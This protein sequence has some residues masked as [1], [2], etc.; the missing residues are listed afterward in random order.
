MKDEGDEPMSGKR[1]LT[2]E[3]HLRQIEAYTAV[4][5]NYRTYAAAI[6]RVLE[7]ACRTSFP[8]AF[9]QSRPKSRS[10]FA[11]K[12]ARKFDK[13]PD[14]VNQMTDLCGGRV[15]VQTIEQVKAVRQFIE[16]NFEILEKED[17]GLLL[18]EDT[19]GYRDMHYIVRL[20]PERD[21]ALGI[22]SGERAAIG[23]RTAEIQVRTW[24]QHAWADTLHDRMYKNDLKLSSEVVR[25][26]ALL[27]AFLEEADRTFH[28]LADELDGLIANYTAFARKDDVRQE[29]AVQR[30]IL[31]HEPDKDKRPALAMKLA[32]LAVASGDSR[33][34]V[35]LLDGHRDLP[36][37]NR[38]ELLLELGYSLCRL[39]RDQPASAEYVRG[40]RLLE[41]AVATCDCQD[42][43][44]APNLRKRD[45]LHARA[46]A[47]LGW[48]LE[49]DGSEAHQ[50]RECYHQAHEHEPANPYYL[51]Q[52]LGFE[53]YCTRG[54]DLPDSMRTTIRRAIRTCLEHAVAGIELPYAHFTA[55]RLSLLLGD[56]YEALGL[57]SRGLRHFLA[58]T[59]CVSG[60]ALAS[61]I[62]WLTRIHF[63]R[64]I[65]PPAQRAIDLLR[66]GQAVALESKPNAPR[67]KAAASPVLIVAGG[68][69]S[70]SADRVE[71]FRPLLQA[72]LTDFAGTVIAGG[73]AVGVPGCVGDV[74]RDLAE[75]GKK[76]FRLVGYL[77]V[78]PPYD[79]PPHKAYDDLVRVGD[80]FHPGQILRSWSDILAAGARPREVTLLG[81]GGGPLS[82]IDYQIALGLGAC[83][84]LVADSGG[85]ATMLVESALWSGVPNLYPLPAD[86]AT[87]RALLLPCH[88]RFEPAAWESMA[89]GFHSAYLAGSRRR[90]PPNMQ[91]WPELA[92]T[93][94]KANFEQAAYSVDILAA[95]GFGVRK[96]DGALR[97]F[98][99]FTEEE[100]ERMAEMEHGRWN[101]E[102]LHDGWRYGKNRDDACKIHDCLVPWHD[103][104]EGI[105]PY[106]RKSVRKFPE[107]L[108]KASL[109]VYRL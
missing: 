22:T 95:A 49:P 70:I 91:P 62:E 101:V 89:E 82:A 13:Y 109:E 68:A 31:D 88:R 39:H 41:E 59:Y 83:V 18:R 106:D 98:T 25:T 92:E 77:P 66:L 54:T 87:L 12:V 55:G 40:R 3:E 7:N 28:R 81:F 74:A 108:A 105:K 93:F 11:E 56:D 46:L 53:M 52:M 35:E 47:R 29:M 2:P 48:A 107:I 100:V 17:K 44:Y 32:R 20:R 102:R 24:V 6:K 79:A 37:A 104:P 42:L 43:P 23:N 65:P 36:G 14:A 67:A 15:I 94:K 30:L 71:R 38:C 27:A 33:E 1:Q 96:P 8:E 61:E 69:A 86:A 57:Y 58:G 63:A 5:E 50:A 64:K 78:E 85:A 97:I 103:L 26:G 99:D 80:G 73:T 21:A 9:V 51:A 90:L 76:G 10:S 34:V 72:A 16:A 60:D 45:S 84:G 19:F 75:Q 4:F